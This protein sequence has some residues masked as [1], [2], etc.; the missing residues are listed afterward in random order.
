MALTVA[1]VAGRLALMQASPVTPPQPT[2]VVWGSRVF[3]TRPQLERWL[4][5]HGA[6]YQSWSRRHQAEAR[7]FEMADPTRTSQGRSRPGVAVDADGRNTRS[8]V[9]AAAAGVGG[10]LL[11]ALGVALLARRRGRTVPI[12]PRR[13]VRRR[14]KAVPIPSPRKLP[15]LLASGLRSQGALAALI[16]TRAGRTASRSRGLVTRIG[17]LAVSRMSS[18]AATNSGVRPGSPARLRRAQL[19]TA[20]VY[21]VWLLASGLIGTVLVLS[22]R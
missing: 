14:V 17:L 21:T 18:L 13:P 15:A 20:V 16:A 5:A 12:R 7:R 4:T 11:L 6:S 2:A 9:A 1:A 10:A 19:R 22:A 3:T 8:L